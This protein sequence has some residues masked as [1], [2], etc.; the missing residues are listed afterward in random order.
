MPTFKFQNYTLEELLLVSSVLLVFSVLSSRISSRF[1]VPAL[2]LFLGIGMLAGSEGLGGINFEDYSL[3]FA[4]GSV[5]LALIIFD[6]GLRT[7]WSTVRPILSLGVSLSLVGTVVTGAVTGVFA[8]YALGLSWMQADRK[9][10][11]V[12]LNFS[13]M[14]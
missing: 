11:P 7:S 14:T 6:G 4:V 8:H 9:N 10:N 12:N 13:P 2:L 1:G 5:C 3:A